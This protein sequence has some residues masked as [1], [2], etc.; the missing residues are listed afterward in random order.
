MKRSLVCSRSE[1]KRFLTRAEQAIDAFLEDHPDASTE[2]W[3]TTF[4]SP[5]Q[6]AFQLLG[7]YGL[8]SLYH[9]LLHRIVCVSLLSITLC[10][11]LVFVSVVI[12]C[13]V[14]SNKYIEV[15]TTEYVLVGIY[16]SPDSTNTSNIVYYYE[17][18]LK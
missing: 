13:G 11:A 8:D 4:G 7:E 12:F 5:E 17:G 16:P 3:E 10:L 14:Q 18:D 1:R 6:F 15:V 2:L 9:T